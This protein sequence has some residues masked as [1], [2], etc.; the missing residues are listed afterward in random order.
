MIACTVL[1]KIALT[2]ESVDQILQRDLL[3]GSLGAAL[4]CYSIIKFKHWKVVLILSSCTKYQ[5]ANLKPQIETPI[6]KN[7]TCS[8]LLSNSFSRISIILQLFISSLCLALHSKVS[9]HLKSFPL[10]FCTLLVY[11]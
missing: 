10:V 7:W 6:I 4:S 11:Y 8:K 1:Y 2:L 9:W 5:E 3:N